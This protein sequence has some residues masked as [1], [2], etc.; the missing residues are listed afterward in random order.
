MIGLFRGVFDRDPAD[1]EVWEWAKLVG[2][3]WKAQG[4]TVEDALMY[5]PGSYHR[6]PRNPAEKINSGYKAWE[7]LHWFMGLGPGYF[8]RLLPHEYWVHVCK[9]IQALRIIH[10][11]RIARSQL[12][13]AHVLLQEFVVD[14]ETLYYQQKTSRLH[15]VRQSIHLL[16]HL[17]EETIRLG[18]LCYM[19]QWPMERC[20]GE[21][22]QEIKQPSNPYANISQRGV[23]RGQVN[24]LKAMIPDLDPP[25]SPPSGSIDCGRGYRMLRMMDDVRRS[26]SDAEH[27]TIIQYLLEN[28]L[29][30][31]QHSHN[32]AVRKWAR[33]SLPTGQIARTA[34]RENLKA[35]GKLRISRNIKLRDYDHNGMLL[36][37]WAEVRYFFLLDDGTEFRPVA[38]VSLYTDLD[39]ELWEQS[40]GAL[41]VWKSARGDDNLRLIHVHQMDS[42]VAMVPLPEFDAD[43]LQYLPDL[44]DAER[45]FSVE[46]FGLEVAHM[47][48]AV[49]D[50]AENEI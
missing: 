10:Q 17:V 44:D 29:P 43:D 25:P 11:R 38:L 42:V 5:F 45:F 34:W 49:E 33:C 3:R 13:H 6:P 48:G 21:Y 47:G 35:P 28:N 27:E 46:Q 2:A 41:Q 24:A 14:F 36:Q 19:S 18:P 37:D 22:G 9:L 32:Y 40:S 1:K 26:V 20:I 30:S 31:F 23:I 12:E 15:F 7:F 50:L 16:L 8:Y 39:Y 4:K